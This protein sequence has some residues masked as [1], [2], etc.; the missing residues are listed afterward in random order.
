ME[1]KWQKQDSTPP[2][3]LFNTSFNQRAATQLISEAREKFIDLKKGKHLSGTPGRLKSRQLP[4]KALPQA[5]QQKRVSNQDLKNEV[6][7]GPLTLD[8][9]IGQVDVV[10]SGSVGESLSC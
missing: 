5:D 1:D 2:R 10:V 9:H 3:S 8:I 7:Y 4:D 6:N